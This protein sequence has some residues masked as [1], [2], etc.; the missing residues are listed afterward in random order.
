MRDDSHH[1][2]LDQTNKKR[3]DPFWPGRLRLEFAYDGSGRRIRKQV[4]TRNDSTWTTT[5]DRRFLYDGWNLIAEFDAN[6]T[7]STLALVRSYTW[8]LDLSG[9]MQGAGGVGG[10]LWTS[11]TEGVWPFFVSSWL[12]RSAREGGA[13]G[14]MRKMRIEFSLRPR[15]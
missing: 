9:S 8:G 12:S 1:S 13:W 11:R 2:K 7:N 3:P 4:K 6:A 15:L 5:T 14:M 10:L